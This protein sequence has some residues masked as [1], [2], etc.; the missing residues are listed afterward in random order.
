MQSSTVIVLFLVGIVNAVYNRTLAF[1]YSQKF[2]NGT[3]H[4]CKTAYDQCSPWSYWGQ[5]S[6]GFQS[7]GGDCANFVSQS[8]VTAGHPYLNSGFPCRGYPCGKEEVGAKNLG[9]CLSTVHN[10]RSS[11]GSRMS[12]PADVKVGDVLIYH[13]SSCTDM[14][15][16]ATIVTSVGAKGD[17]RISCHSPDTFN[18]SWQ[19]FLGVKP[20]TQ[21][22]QYSS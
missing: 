15:A 17:V 3:N 1:Q 16:H 13:A 22:L 20:F 8:L 4:D 14:E 10:W 7:H 9:D 21:W 11:C 12:P 19:T 2:W 6:C 5:E 18:G